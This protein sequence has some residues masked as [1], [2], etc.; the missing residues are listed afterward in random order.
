MHKDNETLVLEYQLLTLCWIPNKS[1]KNL[2]ISGLRPQG[3][4]LDILQKLL[5]AAAAERG[6]QGRRKVISSKRVQDIGVCIK[7]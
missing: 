7:K 4:C 2:Y 1:D 5:I 3:P 6:Q